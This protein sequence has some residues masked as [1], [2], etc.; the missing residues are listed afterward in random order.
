MS[1]GQGTHQVPGTFCLCTALLVLS[2]V[3]DCSF[4]LLFLEYFPICFQVSAN[5]GEIGDAT[6]FNDAVNVQKVSNLLSEYGYHL[7][8]NEVAA[9]QNCNIVR[10]VYRFSFKS[11]GSELW[12]L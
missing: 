6:P 7:R 2:L 5:K 12:D 11:T 1:A 8:G 3:I 4:S 9:C 10:M